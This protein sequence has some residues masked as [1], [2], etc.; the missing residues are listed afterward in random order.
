MNDDVIAGRYR[1]EVLIAEGGMAKVYRGTDERLGRTVAIK[2]LCADLAANAQFVARFEAE[3]KAAASLDHRNVVRIFDTGADGERYYIVMEYIRGS[4]LA[5]VVARDGTLDPSVAVD[6]AARVCD[7]LGAAHRLGIVHRDVKPGNIMLEEGSGTVKVMD[8]GI[9]KTA[10]GNLTQVGDV[11]GTAA[12]LSPEQARGDGVD[13]RSDIY[14][15]G[16]V[17]YQMLTGRAPLPGETLL[18]VANRLA[19]ERP[20]PPSELNSAV[21]AELDAVVMKA[22]EKDPDRRFDSAA[23][24]AR[25]LHAA[26]SPPSA[27]PAP[28]ARSG[29][30]DPKTAVLAGPASREKSRSWGRVAGLGLLGLVA[31]IVGGRLLVSALTGSETGAES[32]ATPAQVVDETPSSRPTEAEVPAASGPAAVNQAVDSLWSF[33]EASITSG[34][35]SVEAGEEILGEVSK[36]RSEYE[37]QDYGDAVEHVAKAREELQ[38]YQ[39]EGEVA[40]GAASSISE[41]LDR[42]QRLVSL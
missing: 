34:E 22:L 36:A 16:C 5:Q 7:A 13:L 32:S 38:E 29:M 25:A 21:A 33:V 35:L 11:L 41:Q 17:L 14:S 1:I 12:Y 23:Q 37:D 27:R 30:A 15:L 40:P 2:V 3:A 26:A 8:F 9:A 28:P 42:L 6:V 20:R 4:T 19:A 39:E 24:M 10:M 18:E 31:L